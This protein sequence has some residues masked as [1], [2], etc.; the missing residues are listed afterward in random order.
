MEYISICDRYIYDGTLNLVVIV[1][2]ADLVQKVFMPIL[3]LKT[4]LLCC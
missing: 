4:I 1:I 3:P 2:M